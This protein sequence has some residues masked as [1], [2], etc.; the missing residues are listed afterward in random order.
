MMD[1]W[2]GEDGVVGAESHQEQDEGE[3][4][5]HASPVRVAHQPHLIGQ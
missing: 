1:I 3:G 2:P 5:D 4:D